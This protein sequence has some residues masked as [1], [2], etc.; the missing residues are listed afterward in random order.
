MATK[1]ILNRTTNK[2]YVLDV[3][4]NPDGLYARFNHSELD[5]LPLR[6]Q[7]VIRAGLLPTDVLTYECLTPQELALYE[8]SKLTKRGIE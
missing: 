3:E 7:H 6:W 5:K 2:A 8:V 4:F 1:F